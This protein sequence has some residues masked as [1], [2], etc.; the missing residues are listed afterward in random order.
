MPLD[1]DCRAQ[2]GRQSQLLRV[3][4]QIIRPAL[5]PKADSETHQLIECKTSTDCKEAEFAP[6]CISSSS[7]EEEE[8]FF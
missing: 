8:S 6:Q 2:T 7:P 5:F 3:T 4:L 1:G